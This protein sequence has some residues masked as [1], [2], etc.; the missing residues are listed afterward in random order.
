MEFPP[1]PL[2]SRKTVHLQEF[3]TVYIAIGIGHRGFADCMLA[4]SGWN[5]ILILLSSSQQNL[6]DIYL[7][8]CRLLMMDRKPARNM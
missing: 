7:L 2:A 6:Y 8:L 5:A 1:D 4:G 3:S